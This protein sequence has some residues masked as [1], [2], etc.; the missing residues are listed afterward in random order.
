VSRCDYNP[1]SYKRN[2]KLKVQN[3]LQLKIK[4]WEKEKVNCPNCDYLI[5]F[6]KRFNKF[7]SKKCSVIFTNKQRGPRS[8]ET[9]RKISKTCIN[10]K[11]KKLQDRFCLS[12]NIKIKN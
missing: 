8:E 11:S 4:N 7:C 6:E 12:C 9:K 2:I 10:R 1:N 3:D 5:P